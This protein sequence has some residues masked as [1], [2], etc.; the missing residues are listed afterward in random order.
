MK[1][2]PVVQRFHRFI[3]HEVLAIF[4]LGNPP[5]REFFPMRAPNAHE[6]LSAPRLQ[7]PARR[8]TASRSILLFEKKNSGDRKNQQPDESNING[9]RR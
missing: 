5:G 3:A 7:I 6:S 1:L 2:A 4:V 8:L 9:E